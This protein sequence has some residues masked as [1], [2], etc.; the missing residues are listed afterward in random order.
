MTQENI[1]KYPFFEL[2]AKYLLPDIVV[3]TKP[4]IDLGKKQSANSGDKFENSAFDMT[5]PAKDLISGLGQR[6]DDR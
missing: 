3:R 6:E 5:G 4:E 1:G 2:A